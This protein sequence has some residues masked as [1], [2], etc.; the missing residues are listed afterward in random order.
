V[1]AHLRDFV[2]YRRAARRLARVESSLDRNREE[3]L[4]AI[5][6]EDWVNQWVERQAEVLASVYRM[7][8]SHAERAAVLSQS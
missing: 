7:Y 4:R 8:R 3:L 5:A 2:L 6:R 1:A